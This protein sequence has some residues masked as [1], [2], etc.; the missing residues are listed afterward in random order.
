MHIS[1]SVSVMPTCL[2]VRSSACLS[3]WLLSYLPVFA[4]QHMSACFLS[5]QP[6]FLFAFLPYSVLLM[7]F[8]LPVRLLLFCLPVLVFDVLPTSFFVVL[9]ACFR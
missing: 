7:F 8:Y 5:C 9:P 2:S 3:V 4:V 1:L 6:V